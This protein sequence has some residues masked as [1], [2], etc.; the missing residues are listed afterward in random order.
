MKRNSLVTALFL[1]VF[2]TMIFSQQT[3]TPIEK[4]WATVEDLATKQLP[5]SA[6]KEVETILSQ[7]KK[8]KNSVEVIKAMV[9]K[10][11]FTLDKNPDEA[12]ALIRDFEA[13]TA[14]STDPAER[15][16]LHSMTAELYAQFYQKDAYTIN[17]RTE[18]KGFIPE[19]IKE[20]TKNIYFDKISIH[21]TASMENP[22]VLQHTD[23]LK[24]AALI[25]KGDDSRIIQPTL[26]DFLG[27]RRIDLLKGLL[28]NA[29]GYSSDNLMDS[30]VVV[31]D[32][33]VV[34]SV[35]VDNVAVDNVAVDSVALGGSVPVDTITA[36]MSDTEDIP[37][38]DISENNTSK[39]DFKTSLFEIQI[40]DT[41]HDIIK[42]HEKEGN[43]QALLYAELQQLNFNFKHA[44]WDKPEVRYL[45]ELNVLEKQFED[46]EAVVEVM[47]YK[48]NY[49]L[50]KSYDYRNRDNEEGDMNVEKIKI[51]SNK[52]KR[53][54]YDICND[55]IKKFPRYKRIQLLENILNIILQKSVH[56]K[57]NEIVK[58][59]SNLQLEI[60]SRNINILKCSVYKINATAIQYYTFIQNKKDDNNDYPDK[61]LLDTLLI[62]VK[63]DPDFGEVETNY[64]L[65]TKDY[66]LYEIWIE[67]KNNNNAALISKSV[68]TVSD[69]TYF[70]R[71]LSVDSKDVY[72]TDR[73]SGQKQTNVILQLYDSKWKGN[74]YSIQYVD[75]QKSDKNGMCHFKNLKNDN[76]SVLF[77][78]RGK[79]VFFNTSSYTSYYDYSNEENDIN[80]LGIFTDRSIYRPGQ[81]VYFKGIAY[82]SNKKRQTVATNNTY[83]ITLKNS[84]NQIISTR[85]LKTNE[86]G[87]FA[88]EFILPNGGLNGLYFLEGKDFSK[89]IYVE[90]YKRPTFEVKIDR[91]KTEVNFGDKAIFKGKVNAFSGY[92]IG[93]AKIKYRI[94][95]STHHYC[96]WMYEP[97]KEIANGTTV[98]GKDGTFVVSFIPEKTNS[99]SNL[100]KNQIF[101]Y[102]IYTD[103]TDSKGETQQCEQS[104]SVGDQSLFIITEMSDK[105][106]K[107][108]KTKI[109]ISTETLNN[110]K[111]NS[112]IIYTLY[113]LEENKTYTSDL[114]ELTNLKEVGAVLTGSFE[115]SDKILILNLN[116]LE[117]GHYKIKLITSDSHGREVKVEKS[118]ILYDKKDKHTPVKSYVWLLTPK[119]ECEVGETAQIIFGTSTKNSSVLYEVMLGNKLL[120]TRW[121]PFSDE[122]KTFNIPFKSSYGAGITV[123]FTFVKDEQLFTRSVHILQKV[124]NKKLTPTLTV[125]RNKLKPGEKAEWTINIPE[126]VQDEKTTELLVGMYDASLDAIRSNGWNFDP[127]FHEEIKYSPEWESNGFNS[128]Y[129]SVASNPEYKD[130]KDFQFDQLNW[131]GLVKYKSKSINR[132]YKGNVSITS[133]DK[134]ILKSSSG[135]DITTIK[136]RMMVEPP[137]TL[138]SSV[139]FT[140]PVIKKD[141]EVN[142]NSELLLS[143]DG[144]INPVHLRT[145][146]NETAFFYPQ[147]RTDSL[148]NVKFTFTTPES[149][150]RWNVKMLAHTKDLYVGQ[151]EAQVVTQKDLMVQMN[152]PRFVRRSDRLV[153]SASVI[154]L[155][156]KE[157]T[158]NVQFEMSDPATEKTIPLKDTAPKTVT[159]AANETRSVEWEIIE[160]SPYELVTCKVTARAGDFSDG[161]QKYLPVLP[162]KVLVTES[163]PLTIRN[164]QTRT[165]SFESLLKNGSNV[166]TKNLTVEFASNPAW[167]AVQA[168]PTLAVPENDNAIDYF[169]AYYANTLAGSLANS[170]PKIAATF[171]R[172][173][174]AGGSREALLSNLDKNTELKNMLLEETPW[175]MAAKDETEQ[176]KQIALLFD[177]NMQ[178][179]QA[180]QYMDKLISLQLP[181]GGFSW[182]K[183][184]PES[185][186]ITQEIMLNLGRLKR[187]TSASTLNAQ[188]SMLDAQSSMLK[189]I[190]YLDLE[191]ARDFDNL[192]KYNKNY[193]KEMS[194]DNMQLFYLHTRSEYPDI[195]VAA[196]AQEAVKF[197]T[198]QSEKYWTSLTLYGKAM[199][200]VVAQRN[201]KTKIATD[202]LASLKENALK[203]DELGMYWAKNTPGYFWNEQPVTIQAAIIEAFAEVTKNNADVDEMN[204]WLLKQKQTQRWDS[205][206]G[207]VDAI[208]AIMHDGSDWLANQGSV[209]ITLGKTLLQPQSV[210]AGTGY[211]KQTIPAAEVKPEMGKVTVSASE[212]FTSGET[213]I[214]TLTK[215][216]IG[217]GSMYWQYDQTLDK[218]TGQSGPL[219]ITKKLFVEKMI[220]SG[221]TLE[222]VEQTGLKKGDKVIT[223]LVITTDRNLEFVAMKDLRAA[224][225]EPVNQLS[226]TQWKEGVCY[227]QTIKDAS[228]Q[229]FFPYLPK[230]TYVF[231][232]ECWANSAGEYSSGIASLQC[233]YAPE[234]VSHTGGE[235]ILII[236]N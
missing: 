94:V 26:F 28:L 23:A 22:A 40:L 53:L 4:R 54:A 215:S 6:L 77:F 8:E 120:E 232:Y 155:T 112:K 236:N 137:P 210:E 9:Y 25:E 100:R 131:F 229:F 234:F 191:I 1:I 12:P 46:N 97:E 231:E 158:A 45:N 29:S 123:M 68:I 184:M 127:A 122:I 113:K 143:E 2:T 145:N 235:R 219:K 61:T 185:R 47:A 64:N 129:S 90:E 116:K 171:D 157:L 30:T 104:L 51:I 181:S 81:T 79:D 135:F 224:C 62:P 89:T 177:L 167:Y 199:M 141:E 49:Y 230:G 34:D 14:K 228:T 36:N 211:F 16:L 168:L 35:A 56:I 209:K 162:D 106:D 136:T 214:K 202:I 75:K 110:E 194:I 7:A 103:V 44:N 164:N 57:Y 174:N 74:G 153:L 15:A 126:S 142:G 173:K 11:R 139:K 111:V 58:P 38:S 42:S 65:K 165:F 220:A 133:R 41:Y 134:D 72:V 95:R 39:T 179:N 52:N 92:S 180:K 105:I 222:P 163:M 154:N 226:G 93:D 99:V 37:V 182:Y 204:I 107:K 147:L 118:F 207:T 198:T 20:W 121:I 212:G 70:D 78:E 19:D 98:S 88:G 183:D 67:D 159:L 144:K 85:K 69:F 128:K 186:Y 32:S 140:A 3:T 86:F 193:D 187:M 138:K 161:E 206:L 175:V 109:D 160:F 27:Y 60:R 114:N 5:E 227:Y 84:N 132:L 10:M 188:P 31:V 130:L 150:T 96:Y 189:A 80:K 101:T 71:S 24:F 18:L 152:L 66:G 156:D 149:L 63:G 87:S 208:Y 205:P 166:D 223:R 48:A 225:F 190:T 200:A 108:Q 217:W 59:K 196:S 203:T 13:F 213:L 102:T 91:L 55:G 195:P 221:K 50:I 83:E 33:V 17:N 119:T 73:Q 82:Y 43:N 21:L 233:Q 115:T 117:S 124:M 216:S 170:N 169:A 197:Y 148:G 201:G 146:F 178:K 76:N 125:F 192:K 218:V 176:K 151:G 172:W